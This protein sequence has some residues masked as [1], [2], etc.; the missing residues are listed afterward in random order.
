[1]SIPKNLYREYPELDWSILLAYRGSF[2]HGTYVPK[3]DPDSIEDM[4]VQGICI[5][6][7][8]YYYGLNEFGSKGTKEIK[9]D[10]W[11]IVLFEFKKSLRMLRAGNPNILSI[12]WLEPKHY[13][14][15]TELG[16]MLID[17]RNLFVGKHAY[18]SFV[19]Y[20]RGQF[21][22]MEHSACKGYMGKKRKELV[23]RFGYDT[24]NA[25]H[26]LRLLKMGI[27][28]L[29]EG[30]LYPER[31]DAELYK[32][33]KKGKWSLEQVK[34]S[35]ERLFQLAEEAYVRSI[36]P[37]QSDWEGI[38]RLTIQIAKKHVGI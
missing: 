15:I 32:D 17:N 2:V 3:D 13:I 23:E 16:Q 8:D 27:E 6:P 37:A 5:P 14:K 4:D 1:M 11:D 19:G 10:E 22:R 38:E 20:A 21:H 31:P 36:L 30:R 28:F 26:L 24:K 12:L 35:A 34:E 33:I 25:A 7:I 9:K 29:T 18:N